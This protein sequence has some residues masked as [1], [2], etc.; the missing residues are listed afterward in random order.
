M[1]GNGL[2]QSVPC[3]LPENEFG[4]PDLSLVPDEFELADRWIQAYLEQLHLA[5]TQRPAEAAGLVSAWSALW[6]IDPV[7]IR[8]VRAVNGPWQLVPERDLWCEIL[9]ISRYRADERL[10]RERLPALAEVA[11]HALHPER[12]AEE[13]GRLAECVGEH[14]ESLSR[15]E[16]I[17]LLVRLDT[18]ELIG[19]AAARWASPGRQVADVLQA[20]EHA[21]LQLGRCAWLFRDAEPWLRSFARAVRYKAV[22]AGL[23]TTLAKLHVLLD[24]A[25][26]ARS[27]H[28]AE[29]EQQLTWSPVPQVVARAVDVLLSLAEQ[30]A[31]YHSPRRV[32]LHAATA[33]SWTLATADVRWISPDGRYVALLELPPDLPT[34][35]LPDRLPVRFRRTVRGISRPVPA[36]PATELAGAHVK[37]LAAEHT[38]RPD[39][40]IALEPQQ[41]LRSLRPGTPLTLELVGPGWRQ[42]W[43]LAGTA[44]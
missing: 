20:L 2:R 9:G 22:D 4:L 13:V 17:E 26:L 11:C 14:E 6:R 38:V 19:W 41:L 1:G 21:R 29:G 16:Q 31:C 43:R 5:G 12:W 15:E 36:E 23:R 33:A 32:I 28:Q 30:I 24:A 8:A 25:A 27:A 7:L 42:H 35:A 39:A 3:E 44:S 37:F 40:R 34:D 10:F 18:M